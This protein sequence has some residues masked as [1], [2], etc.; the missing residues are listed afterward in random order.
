MRFSSH[1]PV[2]GTV[3]TSEQDWIYQQRANTTRLEVSAQRL[4]GPLKSKVGKMKVEKWH[5]IRRERPGADE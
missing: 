1:R 4:S 2:L 5:G 3:Q